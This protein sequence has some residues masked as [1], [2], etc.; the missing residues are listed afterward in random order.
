MLINRILTDGNESM[1]SLKSLAQD[2][3]DR[4][5]LNLGDHSKSFYFVNRSCR[6]LFTVNQR[7]ILRVLKQ[8]ANIA[9]SNQ[10]I[11]P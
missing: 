10:R 11:L 5:G 8:D 9:N 7:Y 4:S 3:L 6:V 2:A 1:A